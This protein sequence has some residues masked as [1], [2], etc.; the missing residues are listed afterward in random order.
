M[1]IATDRFHPLA[2]RALKVEAQE[3]ETKIARGRGVTPADHRALTNIEHTR[4]E[5][6]ALERAR[7]WA[8]QHGGSL[9]WERKGIH[10]LNA[11]RKQMN[12]L[13]ADG[14]GARCLNVEDR[15]RV[16]ELWPDW[17]VGDDID[18]SWPSVSQRAPERD[19]PTGSADVRR[20]VPAATEGSETPDPPV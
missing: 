17:T 20:K 12:E 5:I 18:L 6:V 19:E 11:V 13:K 8:D 9:A 1:T 3:L 15:V 10:P 7:D 4:R 14:L 16:R 2:L